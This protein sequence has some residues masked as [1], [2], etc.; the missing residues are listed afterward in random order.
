M[1][2]VKPK[3]LAINSGSSSTRFAVYETGEESEPV[4]QGKIS[5]IGQTKT[6]LAFSLAGE[7]E[8]S[9]NVEASNHSLAANFLVNWLN[10]Q[11][12]SA[13]IEAVGYRIVHGMK[14]IQPEL[15][16]EN[17]LHDLQRIMTVDPDHL[18]G[19]IEL[20]RAFQKHYSG[21]PHFACFDTAFHH[22]LP[23]V[24]RL[25]P[26]PRRF[27][28]RG[29]QRY[30]FHGL[31]YA[32]LMEELAQI[33]SAA[34]KGKII[35]AHLGSGA[36]ITAVLD[37]KSMDTSMGF[38]PT[39]GLAM[40]TRTGDLDPGVAWYMM[41]SENLSAKQF[42][43][44]VNHQ[45]GWLGISGSADM[46]NLLQQQHKDKPSAEAVALFCYQVKKWIGAYTAVLGG[47]DA[48]VFTGGI[49]ENSPEIRRRICENLLY[50]GIE[51]DEG[52]NNKNADIIS[53]ASSRVTV[54]VIRTNEEWMIA[55][56]VSRILSGVSK[57]TSLTT[58][59]D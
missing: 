23:R 51:L 32:Y 10:Q 45:S 17:L 40:S 59:N 30:G 47:L 44:L 49:G 50:L 20:I 9:Q 39:G 7:P 22:T 16:T 24:A 54:R 11:Q 18:P 8:K 1:K 2:P 25:L 57:K 27:D 35:L 4:L 52:H 55:K 37:G 31:S 15:I 46:Q 41:Q 42:N 3:I 26:I 5:G 58:K 36:S 43:N 21:I 33:D 53:S 14:H 29:V 56:T 34:A 13:S 12:I 38:T 19:E 48:L 6:K 28:E